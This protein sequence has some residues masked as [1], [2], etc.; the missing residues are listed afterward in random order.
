M[1][2]ELE[3]VFPRKR[4]KYPSSNASR[5]IKEITGVN[6]RESRDFKDF[7]KLQHSIDMNYI[8]YATNIQPDD[9]C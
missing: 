8:A 9:N 6:L 3:E 2:D 5:I 4:Y 1:I 7:V